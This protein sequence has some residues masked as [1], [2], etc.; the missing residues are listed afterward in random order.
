M[1][2]NYVLLERIELNASAA[3]VTFANIPQTGYTDLKVVVSARSD[4]A[5]VV[6][7]CNL[8]INGV[9]TATYP[10]RY[11]QGD[12][13]AASS[14]TTNISGSVPIG[15]VTG[16]TATSS[17]FGSVEIYLP[18]YTDSSN[19]QS[20]SGDSVSENNATTSY[21][22]LSAGLWQNNAAITTIAMFPYL[23]TNWLANS[24]FSLYG[25]AA[26]GTT[27]AIAPKA[28][29]GNV[30]ATDGA[31]WYH[32]FLASGTFT[33]QVGLTADV[34]VIAGG[35]GGG[36]RHGGGGGAGGVSYQTS[37]S[38]SSSA[39]IVV[40]AGGAGAV[41]SGPGTVGVNSTFDTST[42]I[43]SNGGGRGSG[44]VEGAGG[45]GGSGGGGDGAGIGGT[46]NQGNTGGATG[47]GFNGGA[48]K[49]DPDYVGGG[50]GGSGAVGAAATST[51]GGNGGAGKNTWSSLATATST[52]VSGFFAGGGGGALFY[53]GGTQ[54]TGGSGGG[55][56]GV[57]GAAGTNGTANTGG[58][59][60][61]NGNGSFAG[62][63]GGSGIVIIRYAV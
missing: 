59:G 35:G 62:G 34:L 54:G 11:V 1:P 3:S 12:G 29:G 58:G 23:G 46:A 21:T 18:N 7:T 50:G 38:V 61:G 42:V 10:S 33:P 30:I 53:T 4:Y 32:A 8:Q 31:Y 27:P 14:A 48:G 15:V 26:L 45:A 36:R 5:G 49:G 19:Y 2:A 6:E 43:T 56:A 55:G 39:S 25:L 22:R 41:T 16:N 63:T 57:Q 51:V 13:A 37:R 24:T 47:Y 17:T 44:N 60:G 20:L 40:G 9:T 28:A 52:G